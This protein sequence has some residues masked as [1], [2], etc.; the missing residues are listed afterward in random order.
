MLF[1][2]L[3]LLDYLVLYFHVHKKCNQMCN[4]DNLYIYVLDNND[5]HI[6]T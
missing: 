5:H 4:Y 2:L 1:Y 6:Y 3:Q